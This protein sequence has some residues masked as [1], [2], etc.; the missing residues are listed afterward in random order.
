MKNPNVRVV[1]A[2]ANEVPSQ[3][4]PVWN[5]THFKS[6][7]Y[8]VFINIFDRLLLFVYTH[9]FP[10]NK[11]RSSFSDRPQQVGSRIYL[12]EILS[13]DGNVTIKF[14]MCWHTCKHFAW[15]FLQLPVVIG[16]LRYFDIPIERRIKLLKQVSQLVDQKLVELL[17]CIR[18]MVV[19]VE[20][21]IK[22]SP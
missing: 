14:A 11:I 12:W 18:K 22:N 1:D 19:T 20:L 8:L 5:M 17:R 3:V 10:P 16:I 15:L 13:E 4:N 9:Y 6:Q 7:V 2:D 21:L